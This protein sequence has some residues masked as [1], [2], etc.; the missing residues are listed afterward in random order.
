MTPTPPS[1]RKAP[2]RIEQL[3]RVRTDDYAWMKD[4][5]WQQVLHDPAA[6]RADIR[7]S[8]SVHYRG[9][10]ATVNSD[11]KGSGHLRASNQ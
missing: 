7:G 10:P 4:A 1:V 11:I 2:Q 8:G 6:L 3:G 9:R 5:D